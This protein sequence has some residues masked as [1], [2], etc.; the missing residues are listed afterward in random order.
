MVAIQSK[1]SCKARLLIAVAD[2]FAC[3]DIFGGH[4]DKIVEMVDAIKLWAQ[5]NGYIDAE[6]TT[7]LPPRSHLL[8]EADH[9]DFSKSFYDDTMYHMAADSTQYHPQHVA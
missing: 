1:V 5:T 2:S 7:E 4:E 3:I 6:P 8:P 9:N